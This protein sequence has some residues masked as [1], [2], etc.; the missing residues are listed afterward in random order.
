MQ[1]DSCEGWV[2]QICGLFNKGRNDE[3][4]PYQ[5]C[6][7]MVLVPT[8]IGPGALASVQTPRFRQHSLSTHRSAAV[9]ASSSVMTW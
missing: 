6:P 8:S 5:V 3:D 2:H 7:C 9:P 1:C 4:M